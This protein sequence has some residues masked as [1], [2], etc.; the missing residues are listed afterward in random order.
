MDGYPSDCDQTCLDLGMIADADD[1]NDGIEDASD[2]F[3]LDDSEVSD[4][5]GDGVG[6]NADVF[7]ANPSETSDYDGDGVGDNADNCMFVSNSSQK[8]TDG[9]SEGDAC[10]LDDDND[11][12]SDE[13]E[14]VDGTNPLDG[15]S[16]SQCSSLFDVDGDGE[17][18]A[19]TDG[20]IIIR[21]LFGFTGDSLTSGALG[22]G[23]SRTAQEI[24]NYLDSRIQ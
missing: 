22:S 2:A 3:P 23:A 1:D 9:D 13:Q 5:D 4:T 14:F 7:P 6:D 11:G 15:A 19:L 10:D 8:N 12:V 21:Y 17:V 20:L 18:R 16:C 24:E